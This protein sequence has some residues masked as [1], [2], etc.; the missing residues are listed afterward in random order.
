MKC[1]S[2]LWIR[3]SGYTVPC[4]KCN[5]CLASKRVDWSFRIAQ[6]LKV[7]SSAL[8]L[9]FTYADECPEI[10]RSPSGLLELDKTHMQLFMKKLRLEQESKLRYYSVGEYGTLTQRP[11]YHSIMFNLEPQVIARLDQIWSYGFVHVGEVTP[12][13]IHY[14]TKYVIDR[15]ALYGDRSPPFQLCHGVRALGR[16]T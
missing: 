3:K 2:P 1:I 15:Q 14:V 10:P 8:F 4:G 11:H 6:E 5:F 7:S 16:I 9:T 13:S 12:A